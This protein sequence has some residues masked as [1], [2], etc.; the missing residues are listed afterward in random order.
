MWQFYAITVD[1]SVSFD[2]TLQFS[3]I[4][5]RVATK[6]FF[7]DF[8]IGNGRFGLVKKARL[9]SG[10]TVAIKRLDL[11]AFKGSQEFCTYYMTLW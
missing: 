11:D 10:V 6:D 5:L 3:L 9:S 7:A 8:I 1:D 2:P 4:E